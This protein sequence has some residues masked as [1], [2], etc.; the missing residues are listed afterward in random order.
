M[1][2]DI[3]HEFYMRMAIE[4]ARNGLA[5]DEVPVGAVLVD[6]SGEVIA[7]G[8]NR[9]IIDSDP[10]A[11]A[12][13]LVLREGAEKIRNYRLLNTILYAT[14]EPCVMCMGAV[15]HARVSKVVF[16]AFDTKWGAAGS[17]YDFSTDKRLNHS[18]K[19]VPGV[20]ADE[21][22]ELIVSFFKNKRTK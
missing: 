14:V 16:G 2:L 6:T 10:T 21:C 9:T 13:I 17:L 4:E 3:S 1:T 22:R 11:H 7:K 12:E 5:I 8:F 18:P 20:L 19:I 15:I